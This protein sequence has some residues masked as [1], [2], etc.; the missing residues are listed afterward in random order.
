MSRMN[1]YGQKRAKNKR[2]IQQQLDNAGMNAA[3]VAKL[4]GVS[5]QAVSKTLNGHIHSEKVLV[6]LRS[7][8]VAEHLLHDPHRQ[9]A[10][11]AQ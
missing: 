8:G 4:A 10:E 9:L 11:T 5:Q 3:M 1:V 7:V 6:A 2:L